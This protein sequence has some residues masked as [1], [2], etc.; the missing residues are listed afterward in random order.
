MMSFNYLSK[1]YGIV[2]SLFCC[3]CLVPPAVPLQLCL[4]V[5]LLDIFLHVSPRDQESQNNHNPWHNVGVSE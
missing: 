2:F 1:A 5:A 4:T 3:Q